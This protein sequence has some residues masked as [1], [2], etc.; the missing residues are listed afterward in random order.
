MQ[1][2]YC[3][4]ADGRRLPVLVNSILERSP[5]GTPTL[6]RT[7]VFNATDRRRYETELLLATQRAQASEQRAQQLA[8]TLQ[9]TLIPPS[10]PTIPGL[11]IAAAYR[12]AGDGHQ[13]GGDFYDISQIGVGDWLVSVGDVAGK[14]AEAAV[15]T[16]LARHTIQSAAI[17]KRSPAQILSHL[18]AVLLRDTTTDRFCTVTIIRLRRNKSR[19]TATICNGGHPQPLLLRHNLAPTTLG[20][21]G[22]LVGVLDTP[23]FHDNKV[24]L[25]PG[26]TLML[27]TDGVTEGRR[28]NEF[29]GEARLA[30]AAS[31]HVRSAQQLCQATLTDVLDFQYGKPRDDIVLLAIRVLDERENARS[32]SETGG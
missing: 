15:I 6:I 17:Q 19:W 4:C 9:Q 22:T 16:A 1:A 29:F 13:V 32:Q 18:N 24:T 27:Y 31:T 2:F 10:P 25:R 21:L 20:Q 3:V 8:R 11:D 12:P 7:A 14:G 26:D 23:N 30:H 5:D 28:G